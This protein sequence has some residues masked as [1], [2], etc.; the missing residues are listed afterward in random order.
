MPCF[1]LPFPS[2][3]TSD[4]V[5]ILVIELSAEAQAHGFHRSTKMTK[6]PA[7]A[8]AGAP[9]LPFREIVR[10][11]ET[12]FESQPWLR[13]PYNEIRMADKGIAIVVND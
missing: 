11:F 10:S 1:S 5:A 2:G 12:Q 4:Q 3:S 13:R 9:V 6:F 8:A 7:R